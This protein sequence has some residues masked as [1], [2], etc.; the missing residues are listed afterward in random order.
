LF[1]CWVKPIFI[2]THARGVRFANGARYSAVRRQSLLVLRQLQHLI[3]Q[4]LHF[5]IF[6]LKIMY[7]PKYLL[8]SGVSNPTQL[9]PFPLAAKTSRFLAALDTSRSSIAG[10]STGGIR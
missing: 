6:N 4:L 1:G 3:Q 10:V 5:I 7:E 2:G 8:T 9:A